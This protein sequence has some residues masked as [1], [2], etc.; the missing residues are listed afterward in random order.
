[1]NFLFCFQL[2]YIDLIARSFL[3]IDD[4]SIC[5]FIMEKHLRQGRFAN[6]IYRVSNGREGIDFIERLLAAGSQLPDMIFLDLNMP[7]MDGFEFLEA[8]KRLSVPAQ[9]PEIVIVTS[10]NSSRD[11]SKCLSMGVKQF[12]TKPVSQAALIELLG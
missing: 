5:N 4:D 8:Y 10:S 1:M 7:I 2:N 11:R 9:I 12:L 3:L 6:E